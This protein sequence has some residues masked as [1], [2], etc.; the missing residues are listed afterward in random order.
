MGKLVEMRN[1]IQKLDN[2]TKLPIPLSMKLA[3][4]LTISEPYGEAWNKAS[5]KVRDRFSVT[6]TN[7]A[8]SQEYSY[9]PQDTLPEYN[10]VVS[11]MEAEPVE[12]NL[13]EFTMKELGNTEKNPGQSNKF[14]IPNEVVKSLYPLVSDLPGDLKDAKAATIPK[15][16]DLMRHLN[17]TDSGKDKEPVKEEAIN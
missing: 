4:I 14:N 1:A 16:F 6:A 13:P 17:G 8:T 2:N 10:K 5:E 7:S 11:S 15:S 3:S 9:I 12:L